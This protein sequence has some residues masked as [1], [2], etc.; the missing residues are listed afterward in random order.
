MTRFTWAKDTQNRRRALVLLGALL[1]LA[2]AA[3]I[4][5]AWTTLCGDPDH[6]ATIINAHTGEE[7]TNCATG[8]APAW[9][10]AWLYGSVVVPLYGLLVLYRGLQPL[11][12]P[13]KAG[14]VLLG[15]AACAAF[16]WLLIGGVLGFVLGLLSFLAISSGVSRIARGRAA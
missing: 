10:Q 14:L 5:L 15:A 11:P 4:A 16:Y 7:R 12:D 3:S 6:R 8:L 2:G 9:M 13:V 1:I